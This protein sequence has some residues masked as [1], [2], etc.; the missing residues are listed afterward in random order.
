MDIYGFFV[1]SLKL[2]PRRH[3]KEL[4]NLP[5]DLFLHKFG[6]VMEEKLHFGKRDESI[7]RREARKVATDNI[8]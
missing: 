5:N 8:N 1:Q 2:G 6:I 3:K 4:V 7:L